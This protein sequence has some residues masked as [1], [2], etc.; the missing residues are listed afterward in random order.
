[1]AK[2]ERIGSQDDEIDLRDLL[3]TLIAGRWIIVLCLIVSKI[4]GPTAD[5]AVLG[6]DIAA[7]GKA[8]QPAGTAQLAHHL[9]HV[10]AAQRVAETAGHRDDGFADQA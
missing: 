8:G 9:A 4:G 7:A 6:R 5:Y 1:M 2:T 10:G 3:G